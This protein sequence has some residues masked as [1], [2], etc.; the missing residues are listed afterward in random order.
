MISNLVPNDQDT[1]NSSLELYHALQGSF[2]QL[3]WTAKMTAALS[4]SSPSPFLVD[5]QTYR[6]MSVVHDAIVAGIKSIVAQWPDN[7][8]LRQLLHVHPRIERILRKA[9]HTYHMGTVRPDVLFEEAGSFKICEI[10]A[11]FP[12]N[13]YMMASVANDTFHNL[14]MD[15]KSFLAKHNLSAVSSLH[16]FIPD[17]RKR[18]TANSVETVW[19]LN[20]RE[21][22]HDLAVVGAVLDVNVRHCRPEQL[23]CHE[24]GS[25]K[26]FCREPDGST[27]EIRSCIL[28]LHQDELLSLTDDVLEALAFLSYRGHALNDFRTI[29]L[30]HDKR[31]LCLLLS[32]HCEIDSY[33]REILKKYIAY[34]TF[35]E[36]KSHRDVK[37][38]SLVLKPCLFGK[39]EGIAMQKNMTDDKFL[40]VT[41]TCARK[42]PHIFQDYVK[43]REFEFLT[44]EGRIEK[45]KTVGIISSLDGKFYGPGIFRSSPGDTISIAGGGLA[46][47]PV[48]EV[49]GIPAQ[50]RSMCSALQCADTS[51]ILDSLS[52]DGVALIGVKKPLGDK[53]EFARFMTAGLGAKCRTHSDLEGEVWDIRPVQKWTPEHARSHTTRP[54]EIHTDASFEKEPP[55]F[56]AMSVIHADRRGGGLFSV[57]NIS[58]AVQRLTEDQIHDL[59]TI[60]AR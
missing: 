11:R 40:E 12:L 59:L 47:Y 45:W 34:T 44:A 14:S 21:P 60:K 22:E 43:Q 57:S 31:M 53:D 18:L 42:G 2:R 48:M 36:D 32:D 9:P 19:I 16:S 10:N 37:G 28:E 29:F 49:Y 55:R 33:S 23:T 15:P 39:G 24:N 26:L 52:R 4:N 46:S 1:F 6:E 27:K 17:L 51:P 58:D 41:E 35:V 30:A 8:H 38:M 50:S 56:V 5:I 3:P 54:F 13:G 20:G 25:S 7:E